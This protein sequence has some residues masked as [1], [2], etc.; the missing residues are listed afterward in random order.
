MNKLLRT[1][2][3]TLL[4]FTLTSVCSFEFG[5]AQTG[6]APSNPWKITSV[7]VCKTSSGP[8]NSTIEAIGAYPVYT[9][10]IPRPVWTVNGAVVEAVPVYE[11]GRLVAFDLLNSSSHLN[12][13]AKNTVK[14][15]L[16]DHNGV[17]VF[18]FDSTKLKPG[19]C[20]EFF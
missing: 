14:F 19:E 18:F 17:R 20:Y 8:L 15:A 2:F 5:R 12:S 16:P 3:A 9:F 13:G 6:A 10:F 1:C 11:H 7:R 4:L